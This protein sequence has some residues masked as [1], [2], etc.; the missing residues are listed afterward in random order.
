MTTVIN[1]NLIDSL[2]EIEKVAEKYP[3]LSAQPA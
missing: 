2:T 3:F 1:M